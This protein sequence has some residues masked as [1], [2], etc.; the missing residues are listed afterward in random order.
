[1]TDGQD[2]PEDPLPDGQPN[3]P[4]PWV[5][6]C[7]QMCAAHNAEATNSEL[8]TKYHAEPIGPAH[9]SL[10]TTNPVSFIR[11]S[12]GDIHAVAAWRTAWRSRRSRRS[13]RQCSWL[14]QWRAA[15]P[16]VQGGATTVARV[17]VPCSACT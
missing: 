11:G 1:M 4:G 10:S 3:S 16:A 2:P 7:L 14:L 13:R 8:L 15:E 12:S 17:P 6:E 9:S 5:A